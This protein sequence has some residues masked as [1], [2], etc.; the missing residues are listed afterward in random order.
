MLSYSSQTRALGLLSAAALALCLAVAPAHAKNH[1]AAKNS[2]NG[3]IF[4]P[5]AAIPKPSV[6][7]DT[8]IP[9]APSQKTEQL[10]QKTTPAAISAPASNAASTPPIRAFITAGCI[11]NMRLHS[12]FE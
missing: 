3:G 7:L 12:L 10:A 11:E 5:P 4:Q 9:E 1:T 8:S 6:V 2:D